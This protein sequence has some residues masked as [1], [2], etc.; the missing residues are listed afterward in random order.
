MQPA[1]PETEEGAPELRLRCLG[2]AP[3]QGALSWSRAGRVLGAGDPEGADP[4][5]GDRIQARGDQLLIARPERGDQ[6][7]YTCRV[8]S[9]LGQ[10]EAAADVSVLCERAGGSRWG[11]WG[12]PQRSR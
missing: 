12:G 1:N 11:A 10:A 5:T 8:Q 4:T 7:R 2:W 9:P 3:G 6:G